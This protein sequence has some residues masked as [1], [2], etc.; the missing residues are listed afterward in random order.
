MLPNPPHEPAYVQRLRHRL[1]A[2]TSLRRD[3]ERELMATRLELARLKSRLHR[4]LATRT[5]G[6]VHG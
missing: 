4:T 3:K 5:E 2:E 1:A 6:Q